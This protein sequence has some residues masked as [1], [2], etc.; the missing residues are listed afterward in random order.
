MRFI[1][2]VVVGVVFIVGAIIWFFTSSLKGE[3]N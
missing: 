3:N 2:G 1:I